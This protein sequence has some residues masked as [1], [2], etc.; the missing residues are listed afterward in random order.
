VEVEAA[1]LV[2][3]IIG[4]VVLGVFLLFVDLLAVDFRRLPVVVVLDLQFQEIEVELMTAASTN[5]VADDDGLTVPMLLE[6]MVVQHHLVL[7][8]GVGCGSVLPAPFGTFDVHSD[9]AFLV[10]PALVSPGEL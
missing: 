10:A 2:E 3:G 6:A 7:L 4:F 1:M 5:F 9:G 8:V